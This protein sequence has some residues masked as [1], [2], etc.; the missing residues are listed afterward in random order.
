MTRPFSHLV[1]RPR[2]AIAVVIVVLLVGVYSAFRMPVAL[3]PSVVRPTVNVACDYP[4]A[5]AREVMNTVAGPIEDQVN[6]VEGMD[7]MC[8]TCNDIG[9]YSLTVYFKVGYDRDV[10][11]MK[12]QSKVQQALSQLPQEVKSTGV[13]VTVGEVDQLGTMTLW[14][15]NG[16]LTREEVIDYTYGVVAPALSLVP[17]IAKAAVKDGKPAM[18]VWL[19]PNRMAALG[20]DTADVIAAI[21]SQNVQASLGAVGAFPNEKGQGRVISLISKGRLTDP[22]EFAKIVVRTDKDG[23][24]VRLGDV[25]R[26]RMGFQTYGKEG[27]HNDLTSA[28]LSL[29]LLPGTDLLGTERALKE[30]MAELERSFPGDL[31]WDMSYSIARN[32]HSALYNTGL[33]VALAFLGAALAAILYLRSVRGSIL[34]VATSFVPLATSLVFVVATGNLVNL[35]TLYSFILVL[36][37]SVVASASVVGAIRRKVAEGMD[38]RRAAAAVASQR[39]GPHLAAA[40]A[41]V[42]AMV[43]IAMVDGVQ[44]MMYRQFAV[45]LAPAAVAVTLTSIWIIP[46]L[47][48]AFGVGTIRGERERPRPDLVSPHNTFASAVG[49]IV[50]I[51]L[52]L[53]AWSVSKSLPQEFIPRE[54]RGVYTIDFRGG[55]GGRMGPAIG[56]VKS[57]IREMLKIEGTL[58]ATTFLGSSDIAGDGEGN[59]IVRLNLKD[60]SERGASESYD[61]IAEKVRELGRHVPEFDVN[62][63]KFPPVPGIGSAEGVCI[64]IQGVGEADPVRFAEEMQRLK[65]VYAESPLAANVTCG[66]SADTPHLRVH[67]DREKCELMNVPMS[68][69]YST[70]Q[71]YLGSFYVNDINLGTQVNRVTVMADWPGRDT[72]EN[73]GS[74]YVRSDVGA[75][76][77]VSVLV[78]LEEELGIRCC[79]RY[80]RYLYSTIQF[81]PRPGVSSSEAIDEVRRISRENLRSGYV[82]GWA[83]L[84]YEQFCTRGDSHVLLA[85]SLLMVFLVLMVYY[86]SIRRAVMNIFP[87]TSVLAGAVCAHMLSGVTMSLYSWFAILL[88]AVLAAAMSFVGE[89]G[90]TWLERA[91]GP[92]A[93]A[94]SSLPLVFSKGAV[95]AGSCSLGVA[96]IGGFCAYAVAMCASGALT[97][98]CQT[99]PRRTTMADV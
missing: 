1:A 76:V 47:A 60:W 67:V 98:V 12:V 7:H 2:A 27:L 41:V 29:F 83:N 14:S 38:L 54:D 97:G 32:L 8:S 40:A 35:L 71:H 78:K 88:M 48:S 15:K 72:I 4:G 74:L 89:G 81:I 18:R 6:G 25:G 53:G 17:G 61:S 49:V 3:Y 46:S 62:V 86:E 19:D 34:P 65:R 96:L 31:A 22:S 63:T 66:T 64:L 70:L 80:N 9:G 90:R 92:F 26:I 30:K 56:Q 28:Y 84:T 59:A 23:G 77:P 87:L 16:E 68:S 52:G 85:V 21:K 99:L 55:E 33:S 37:F 24:L 11:L 82:Q 79:Y 75:M 20:I 43:P 50:F 13:T 73:V 93:M 42:G 10:A 36:P 94:L 91:F 45:V 58:N 39:V 69:L 44:G 95:A 5:S 57:F 51:T